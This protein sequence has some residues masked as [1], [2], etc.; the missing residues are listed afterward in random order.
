MKKINCAN[1]WKYCAMLFA[2]KFPEEIKIKIF[3]FRLIVSI[4]NDKLISNF[5]K[6]DDFIQNLKI[7]NR[8]M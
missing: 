4:N 3:F 6:K 5:M 1:N 8:K 2:N 7:D